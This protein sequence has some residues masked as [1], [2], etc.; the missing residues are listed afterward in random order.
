MLKDDLF[1]NLLSECFG[2]MRKSVT[3]ASAFKLK[4]RAKQSEIPIG[5][6]QVKKE[7]FEKDL[8]K[9]DKVVQEAKSIL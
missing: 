6:R 5:R 7:F 1:A 4:V 2:S 3:F 9:T 8:H